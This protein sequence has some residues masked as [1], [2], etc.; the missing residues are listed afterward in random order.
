MP[1]TSTSS[2][3]PLEFSFKTAWDFPTPVFHEI[4]ETFPDLSFRCTCYDEGGNFAG[5][6]FFNP[7]QGEKD[8]AICD[9]TDHLFERV[10]GHPRI[11]N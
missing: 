2:A 9:A 5:D 10:Y 7:R 8:F 6:G 11:V 4:A 1:T 3:K